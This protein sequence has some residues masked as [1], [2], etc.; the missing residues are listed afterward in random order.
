[1]LADI[2][3]AVVDDDPRLI[4]LKTMAKLLS[5][6]VK[7]EI[8][9]MPGTHDIKYVFLFWW[10]YVYK[11]ALFKKQHSVSWKELTHGVRR[12][13]QCCHWSLEYK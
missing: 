12:E 9:S 1:M 4:P 13:F 2:K 8:S 6:S 3:T 10:N 5:L 11:C 7:A